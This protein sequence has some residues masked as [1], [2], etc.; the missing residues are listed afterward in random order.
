MTTDITSA[1]IS[2]GVYLAI[3]TWVI[4]ACLLSLYIFKRN[5][6]GVKVTSLYVINSVTFLIAGAM[7]LKLALIVVAP[8]R[9]TQE[10]SLEIVRSHTRDFFI[11]FVLSALVITAALAVLNYL[12]L[13]YFAKVAVLK[14]ALS[15]SSASLSLLLLAS[16]L[17]TE[18]YYSQMVAEI[19]R[20]F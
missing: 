3:G 6:K 16:W 18:H 8:I 4:L 7:I 2:T 1:F 19:S 17:S 11:D 5:Y 10:A 14:H 12:Y 15:L 20:H 9:E 13:K